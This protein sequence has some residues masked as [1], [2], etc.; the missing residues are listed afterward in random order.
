MLVHLALLLSPTFGLLPRVVETIQRGHVAV[1]ENY[2][3][4]AEVDVLRLDAAALY[5]AGLYNA[6]SRDSGL[7]QQVHAERAVLRGS[8][9]RDFDIG[10]GT[11]RS[12]LAL[13]IRRLRVELATALQRDDL[14]NDYPRH[15]VSYTRF[16]KGASLARLRVT[17]G[18]LK[19]RWR[20][21]FD[22]RPFPNRNA[23]RRSQRSHSL[24]LNGNFWSVLRGSAKSSSS[25]K[26]DCWRCP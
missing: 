16:A 25:Y 4:A 9:W 15:E 11:A 24:P 10:D 1:V 19:T 21:P 12:A 18:R 14:A 5:K 2:L 26:G 6:P 7:K 20:C 8:T 22:L 17:Q 13:K 23:T 3:T